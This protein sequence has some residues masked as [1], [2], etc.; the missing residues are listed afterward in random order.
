[1][2]WISDLCLLWCRKLQTEDIPAFDFCIFNNQRCWCCSLHGNEWGGFYKLYV[3][4]STQL[5]FPFQFQYESSTLFDDHFFVGLRCS[6]VILMLQ[7]G[8][9]WILFHYDSSLF[10]R[11]NWLNWRREHHSCFF[12]FSYKYLLKGWHYFGPNKSWEVISF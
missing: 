10:L 1:M 7:F 8:I 2:R 6:E 3:S 9:Y 12:F 4:H 11:F 5:D